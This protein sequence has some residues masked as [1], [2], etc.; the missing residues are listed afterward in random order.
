MGS[1]A[2][3]RPSQMLATYEARTPDTSRVKR[4]RGLHGH[5]GYHVEARGCRFM[6]DE[7]GKRF[8]S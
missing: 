2:F 5:P 1:T 3:Q 8:R 7:S 4:R 6:H